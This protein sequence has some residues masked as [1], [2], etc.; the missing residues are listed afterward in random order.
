M[1]QPIEEGMVLGGR[2]LITGHVLTS[3]DQDMVLDGR[4]QVLNRDVSILVASSDNASQVAASARELA[5]GERQGAIQVLDLGLSEGR[6]YLIA[7]GSP[8]PDELLDMTREQQVY[9]EPFQTDTLGSEIFGEARTYEP[10]VYEDDEDYYED[11]D[12]SFAVEGPERRR[13]R[14]LKG[15]SERLSERLGS[16]DAAKDAVSGGGATAVASG[17]AADGRDRDDDR[18]VHDG[19]AAGPDPYRSAV[20]RT[21]EKPLPDTVSDDDWTGTHEVA[22]DPGPAPDTAPHTA[23][24]RA[25]DTG[26]VRRTDVTSGAATGAATAAANAGTGPGTTGSAAAA[27]TDAAQDTRGGSA[28]VEPTDRQDADVAPRRPKVSLWSDD[29]GDDPAGRKGRGAGTAA[30]AGLAAGA[31]TAA[32]AAAAGDRRDAPQDA[33]PTAPAVGAAPDRREDV[34]AFADDYEDEDYQDE[35]KPGGARWILGGILALVLVLGAVFAFNLLGNNRDPQAGPGED[36]TSS[37]AAEGPTEQEGASDLPEPVIAGATRLVPDNP[38]LSAD[39]DNTLANAIDGNPATAWQTFSF[40]QPVFGGY[41]DSMALVIEL[42]EPSAISQV[43]IA[44]NNGSGGSFSVLLNDAPE[45]DGASQIAEG[46]F[47]G[48]QVS[49][50]V[51]GENGAPAEA[52]YV[53]INFTELPQL[54]NASANLPYGLRI[55]EVEVQ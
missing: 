27:G 12:D 26:K 33:G 30:A 17:A 45:L 44:Q 37:P 53:I 40:A 39:T 9:V 35:D 5:T 2:Y 32:T 14:F 36:T 19:D 28:G 34:D 50:P 29:E 24:D 15:I 18:P 25:A 54:S 20:R 4:D 48:P 41:A 7:G 6:T 31:A 21:N 43:D 47:T 23:A 42:E 16:H 46:S 11:L 13:P 38:Q 1:P 52:R 10:H 55:A 49:V 22:V 3:A 51:S 8:E